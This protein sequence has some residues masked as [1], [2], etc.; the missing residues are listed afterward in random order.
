MF[1]AV[2]LLFLYFF[3]LQGTVTLVTDVAD[4]VEIFWSNGST[5]YSQEHSSIQYPVN[6]IQDRYSYRFTTDN[7]GSGANIRIDPLRDKGDFKIF[8][9][10]ISQPGYQTMVVR[11]ATELACLVPAN[12]L[13]EFRVSEGGISAVSTGNDPQI[14]LPFQARLS[15]FWLLTRFAASLVIVMGVFFIVRSCFRHKNLF[16]IVVFVANI[17]IMGLLIIGWWSSKDNNL[18]QNGRWIIG[19]DTGKFV[20]QTYEFMSSPMSDTGLS[21][22]DNMGFQ[23]ILYATHDDGNRRIEELSSMVQVGAQAY[24]W[25]ELEKNGQQMLGVRISRNKDYKS[26]FYTYSPAGKLLNKQIID[27]PES[28]LDSW[29]RVV[30]SR[31]NGGW[32]LSLND[33]QLGTNPGIGIENSTFGFRGCS[34][35]RELFL[36]DIEMKFVDPVTG[37]NWIEY[38]DFGTSPS[39]DRSNIW[40]FVFIIIVLLIKAV[41]DEILIRF[42][43]KEKH[44]RF[45]ML[46]QAALFIPGL[47]ALLFVSREYIYAAPLCF[48]IA[49]LVI[50]IAFALFFDRKKSVHGTPKRLTIAYVMCILLV[51]GAAVFVNDTMLQSSQIITKKS[52]SRIDPDIYIITPQGSPATKPYEVSGTTVIRPGQPFFVPGLFREQKI[53]FVFSLPE[54]TTLDIVFEQQGFLTRGDQNGEIIPLQRRLLRMSTRSGVTSGLS[55]KTGVRPSPFIKLNGELLVNTDN[56]ASISVTSK[57]VTLDLNGVITKFDQFGLLGLGETGFLTYENAVNLHSISVIPTKLNLVSGDRIYSII[58]IAPFLLALLL[59]LFFRIAGPVSFSGTTILALC[60]YY[61]ILVFLTASMFVPSGSLGFLRDGRL[62]WFFIMVAAVAVN[63]FCILVYSSKKIKFTPVYANILSVFVIVAVAGY[64]YVILPDDNPIKLKFSHNAI[65]PGDVAH[66]EKNKSAPW[67][68]NNSL[69]GTNIW[70]WSQLFG[71]E[72]VA[73]G[74]SE[75]FVRIFVIGGSQAWGSGAA[76]SHS[77]FSKLLE[78]KLL[79]KGLPVQVLNA[80]TNAVGIKTITLSNMELLPTFAP[81]IIIIDVGTNDSGAIHMMPGENT[82]QKYVHK[83]MA[84]FITFVDFFQ[85]KGVRIILNLEAMCA[86]S[87]DM[88]YPDT[89]LYDG[90]KKIA[91]KKGVP[92]V[93]PSVVTETIE[94]DHP[95]WWD[96]AHLTP[97][98]Q[99]VFAEVLLPATEKMVNE[100]LKE[101]TIKR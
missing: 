36:R 14:I 31:H 53:D 15:Y 49:E 79:G 47:I 75:D 25:V 26:G 8:S 63:L 41:R 28:T 38:E 72:K 91:E 37:K 101:S 61:P 83:R 60:S 59:F 71:G 1:S 90:L 89:E 50:V 62:G 84:D 66:G 13:A 51:S 17:L 82:Q 54:Q 52:L 69:I 21:L 3:S 77:T 55:T 76:D 81:D 35:G 29:S 20:F 78:K 5:P 67:Y 96:I 57:G 18:Y 85:K 34:S 58:F 7:L 24:I 10:E 48:L 93:I 64:V 42:I 99:D 33:K 9:V 16:N 45:R 92:V 32:I 94:K 39:Q 68:A 4:R 98:G 80:G 100:V 88:V 95:L 46:S 11:S 86:E 40:I 70:V 74:K 97:Y 44:Y 43:S 30:L 22:A 2:G 27:I 23:E 87:Y 73:P 12:H 19:K 65:A 6:H 56:K